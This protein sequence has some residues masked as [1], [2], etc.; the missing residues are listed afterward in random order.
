[1][2]KEL[3]LEVTNK[4]PDNATIEEIIDAILV[5]LSIEKGLKD[6]KE[7]KVISHNE[8]KKEIEKW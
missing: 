8:L 4:M 5:R 6:V 1:M 3:V 2:G 7:G